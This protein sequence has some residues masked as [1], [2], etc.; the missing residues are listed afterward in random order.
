MRLAWFASALLLM[1]AIPSNAAGPRSNVVAISLVARVVPV[2]YLQADSPKATGATASVIRSGQ[3]AFTLQ[4]TMDGGEAVA[5]SIASRPMP[6]GPIVTFA[7]ASG[8]LRTSAVGA[9]LPGTIVIAIPPG[10]VPDGKL[11]SVQITLEALRK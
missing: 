4:F 7:V 1:S 11:A 10:A 2:L 6:L 5:S 3:N 8:L 9:P